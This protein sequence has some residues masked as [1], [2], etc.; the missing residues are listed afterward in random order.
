MSCLEDFIREHREDDVRQLA[1]QGGRYPDVDM[2]FAL[3]QIAGWQMA[4]KK[5]PSWAAIDGIVYPPHLSMEQCSSEQT[6]R[7]KALILSRCTTSWYEVRGARYENSIEG[8]D[9]NLVPRTSHHAPRNIVDLTGGLGVDFA[10]LAQ[11]IAPVDYSLRCGFEEATATYVERQPHLCEAARKNF[12]LLGLTH[13]EVVC[14]DGVEYLHQLDRATLIYL[15]PAR[16]D[17]HGGRTYAISDCTPDVLTLEEELLEKA[18]WVMLKLSP[19]LDWHKA[20]SDL[21]RLGDVVR[22]VHIVSV[23]NECKELL[24]L[25]SKNHDDELSIH[26]VNDD[27][28]FV[29]SRSEDCNESRCEGAKV[30]RFAPRNYLYEPNA[31]IMKAG[32][33]DLL[34]KRLSVTPIGNNSHLFVSAHFIEDFPGRKFQISAVSSVNKNVTRQLLDSTDRANIAVR[35]FPMTADVLRKKLKLKDGGDTYIFGTTVDN[36]AFAE[37]WK[38]KSGPV[39]VIAKKT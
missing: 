35:N 39:L 5:I 38:V 22:E 36:R 7:Y 12:E 1:L 4:R 21:N 14:G 29:F 15:D 37:I 2:A 23:G 19:M 3:Q 6:A 27:S 26:C 24:L 31:S 13:A 30:R 32:C 9:S 10:F 18:E 8:L 34:Q 25:L 20:V 33:F 17:G 28:C 11:A 16:R